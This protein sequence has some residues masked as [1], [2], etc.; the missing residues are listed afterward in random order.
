MKWELKL[1]VYS[2]F[3]I[4]I[5][6]RVSTDE[7][8][9]SKDDLEQSDD[10]ESSDWRVVV[11]SLGLVA[12]RL[13]FLHFDTIFRNNASHESECLCT[14]ASTNLESI[15]TSFMASFKDLRYTKC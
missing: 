15:I 11:A 4:M 8:D 6:N 3:Y 9:D 7:A 2:F 5:S 10:K 1:K 14:C 12:R 13:Q